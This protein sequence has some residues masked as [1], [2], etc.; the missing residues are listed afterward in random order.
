MKDLLLLS[1]KITQTGL[2][3]RCSMH[4]QVQKEKSQDGRHPDTPKQNRAQNS[5]FRRPVCFIRTDS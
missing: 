1:K 5:I 3:D 4:R 2:G